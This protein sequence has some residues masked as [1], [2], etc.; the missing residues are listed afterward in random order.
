MARLVDLYGEIIG[1]SD[2]GRQDKPFKHERER[3]TERKVDVHIHTSVEA[4]TSSMH[5][6]GQF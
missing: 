1:F 5:A 6:K 4:I 2:D 3:E